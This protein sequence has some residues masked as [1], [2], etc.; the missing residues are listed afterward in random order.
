[1]STEQLTQFVDQL[2]E[3][4]VYHVPP[5]CQVPVLPVAI[6]MLVVGIGLAVLGAKLA[7]FGIACAFGV[8]GVM[9]AAAVANHVEWPFIAVCL[10]GVILGAVIG[11]LLFRLW[12]G[13]AA[14]ALLSV[15]AVG[16]YGGQVV[17]PHFVEYH[18]SHEFEGEFTLPDTSSYETTDDAIS[19]IHAKA[20][21]FW[22]YVQSKETDVNKRIL[23]VGLAA[24]LAGFLLGSL[25]PRLTLIVGSSVVGIVLVMSGLAGVATHLQM[26]L[27]QAAPQYQGL[28]GV[29][30]LVFLIASLLLQ[31][32]LTRPAPPPVK[33]S[34]D[35]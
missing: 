14:A 7:R 18:R 31:C 9:A 2:R 4:W 10:L 1:M 13:L 17:S 21:D 8:G 27:A 15:V 24:A 11:H 16:A 26:D 32:L 30:G 35:K 20:N 25:L 29:A 19:D 33:S 23:V 28:I 5:E 34:A 3:L 12:V 22:L 6:G